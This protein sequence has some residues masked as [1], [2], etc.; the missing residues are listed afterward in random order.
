[1]SSTTGWIVGSRRA[2]GERRRTGRGHERRRPA[3]DLDELGQD[4]QGDL[5][6]GLATEIETGR[7][8][9]RGQP[10]L[11]DRRPRR[12]ATRGR[13]PR[14]SARRPGPRTTRHVP[15]RRPAPPRPRRPCVATTTAGASTGVEPGDVRADDD[16]LGARE[17]V[18]VGDRV[19]DRDA[20]AGRRAERDQGRRRWASFRPPTGPAQA[21]AVPRRSPACPL[22]GRS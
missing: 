6:G 20:P 13:R 12:G 15:A 8:A 2:A 21:D 17:V 9:Q 4:R 5:L 10:L 14:A 1:M 3:P 7:G 19:E 22:S 11:R 16:P 18:R